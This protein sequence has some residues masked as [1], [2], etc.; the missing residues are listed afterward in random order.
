[1]DEVIKRILDSPPKQYTKQ[2]ATEMLQRLG[3]LDDNGE[4]TPEYNDI[5]KR[6]ETNNV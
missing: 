5:F 1:M 6:K 3:V 2:E 4:V